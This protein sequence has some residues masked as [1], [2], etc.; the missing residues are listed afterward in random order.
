MPESSPYAL[1]RAYEGRRFDALLAAGM[2]LVTHALPDPRAQRWLKE[3]ASFLWWMDREAAASELS[4]DFDPKRVYG[5]CGLC[6]HK[7]GS[8][9]CGEPL[10]ASPPY[11]TCVCPL[12][13]A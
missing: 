10:G 2:D 12:G 4:R 6:R 7:H 8:E 11:N 1:P 5:T 9:P 13:E 3:T